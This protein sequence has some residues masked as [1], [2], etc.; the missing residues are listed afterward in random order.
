MV[1]RSGCVD[2]GVAPVDTPTRV[3]LD[4]SSRRYFGEVAPVESYH[5][6]ECRIDRGGPRSQVLL[7]PPS[8]FRRRLARSLPN[9]AVEAVQDEQCVQWIRSSL[10]VLTLN[11][12]RI[13]VYPLPFFL[14]TVGIMKGFHQYG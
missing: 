5:P 11:L 8:V 10:S 7:P 13:K 6:V 14:N 3:D 12:R 4:G 1:Y 9:V 2:H